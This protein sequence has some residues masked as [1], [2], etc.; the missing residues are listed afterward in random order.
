MMGNFAQK[1]DKF[2]QWNKIVNS[3]QKQS[4]AFVIPDRIED[5]SPLQK[6]EK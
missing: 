6:K 4:K 2:E 3:S 1:S 5:L